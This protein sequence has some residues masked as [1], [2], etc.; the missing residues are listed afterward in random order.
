MCLP[1]ILDSKSS[2]CITMFPNEKISIFLQ[3]SILN[4]LNPKILFLSL[5]KNF[6]KSL[7]DSLP[8][9]LSPK[10]KNLISQEPRKKKKHNDSSFS[11]PHN[12]H[13]KR[14]KEKEKNISNFSFQTSFQRTPFLKIH[15]KK[16]F[17]PSKTFVQSC[18]ILL[19]KPSSFVII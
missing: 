16:I 12:F 13:K 15:L 6:I 4:V 1:V 7:V 18:S 2:N 9:P 19:N 3:L 17:F 8:P 11:R 14:K 5:E 10:K